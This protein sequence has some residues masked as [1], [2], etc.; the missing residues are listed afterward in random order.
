MSK[1]EG[2]LNV[3]ED[4]GHCE[5]AEEGENDDDNKREKKLIG[6]FVDDQRGGYVCAKVVI[7]MRIANIVFVRLLGPGVQVSVTSFCVKCLTSPLK[8]YVRH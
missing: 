8:M 3:D 2:E 1:E 6:T 7:N 4:D 5:K